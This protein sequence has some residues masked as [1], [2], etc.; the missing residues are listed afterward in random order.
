M[1]PTHQPSPAKHWCFTLNNPTID[2]DNILDELDTLTFEYAVFQLEEGENGTPHFQG[3][4]IWK[5]KQRLTAVRNLMGG[6]CHWEIAR[7]TPEQN[8]IYCTKDEGRIGDFCE[9][10]L[11]PEN[12]QG[13][14][15]DLEKLHSRLKEGLTQAE[16]VS[17]FFTTFV[18][19]PNLVQNYIV[20]SIE[21]RPDN[22]PFSSWLLCGPPG[23]GK[24]RLARVIASRINDGRLFRHCLGKWFDGYR[25]ERTVLLDDFCGS[26][27][28]FT[29]FKC[30]LDRYPLRVEL[31]GL[32]CEM[33]A[34]HFL[35]TTNQDPKEWWK[36]EVTGRY[37]HDAIFRRI[38]KVLSFCG[39]NQFRVYSSY[40]QY[41]HSE[42]RIHRDGEIFY[43]E[44]PVQEVFYE[45]EEVQLEEEILRAEVP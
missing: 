23:T 17:E 31:K 6:R 34:T 39:K 18:K 29:H 32:T 19:Y 12:S 27:L 8:R 21:P 26:S 24:S 13:K 3:Y 15:N 37:G 36:A 41:A 43:Q 33:A 9:S 45:G 11:F 4:V 10:G 7:G 16:Y 38:G 5:S 22:A 44:R 35:I 14:R 2:E 20:S 30:L 25:G 42:L 40:E 28:S 1:P